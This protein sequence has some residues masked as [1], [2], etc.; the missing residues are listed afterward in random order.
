MAPLSVQN[1]LELRKQS[2][3]EDRFRS[4]ALLVVY[5]S[6]PAFHPYTE[7]QRKML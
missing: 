4:L 3:Y 2:L 5:K 6:Q 1:L 7:K